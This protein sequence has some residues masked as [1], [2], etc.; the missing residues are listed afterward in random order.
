MA[1]HL[2]P[3]LPQHLL[4]FL[5]APSSVSKH[6]GNINW[7]PAIR[8]CWCW[9]RWSGLDSSP[10]TGSRSARVDNGFQQ[11]GRC[12]DLMQA[13]RPSPSHAL[14]AAGRCPGE[15][16]G[17]PGRP[18]GLCRQG[19]RTNHLAARALLASSLVITPPPMPASSW[20]GTGLP[21]CPLL[22]SRNSADPS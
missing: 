8:L 17:A 11:I 4:Q 13:W 14:G 18:G 6:I 2:S 21:P 19:V 20:A 9:L 22:H 3:L 16:P 10:R 1:D 12:S 7:S 5:P 15:A